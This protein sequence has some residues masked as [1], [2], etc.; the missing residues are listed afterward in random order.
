[1]DELTV[2][3]PVCD[4]NGEF[5]IDNGCD[6]LI[7]SECGG[8][9]TKSGARKWN[10]YAIRIQIQNQNEMELQKKGFSSAWHICPKQRSG[11]KEA[12]RLC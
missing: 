12:E 1:M 4:G 8:I 3:C 5:I 9:G 11:R 2:V 7:C 10:R 6:V